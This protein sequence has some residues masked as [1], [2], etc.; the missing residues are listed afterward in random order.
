M[1]LTPMIGLL[2]LLA[3]P[4]TAL[5]QA[6]G[7]PDPDADPMAPTPPDQLPPARSSNDP[8]PPVAAPPTAVGGVIRQAGIG[9]QVGFGRAGVLE[10]GGSAGFM[11]SS[12]FTQISLTPSFG[13]FI[14]DNLQ[15]T[16]LMGL[17]YVSTEM[18]DGTIM[19]ALFEPSYHLP[20]SRTTFG[21]LGIGAGAA[22]VEGPGL[23]FA[24]APRIGAKFL[25]GRSGLLTPSLS[26]QYSTHETMQTADGALLVVSS[27]LTANIGYTVMW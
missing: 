15:L 19:T 17:T 18:D 27:S 2:A 3:A 23:G 5:A 4:A 21:F 11:T 13:W 26:W 8:P 20:F 9:S 12:R 1:R 10:L 22:Y 6:P 25:V 16:A 24:L 7:D 14:A